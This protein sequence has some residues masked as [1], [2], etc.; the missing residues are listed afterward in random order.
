[1]KRKFIF[2]GM[3]FCAFSFFSV[4]QSK[5]D[6]QL[7]HWIDVYEGNENPQY[8]VCAGGGEDCLGGDVKKYPKGAILV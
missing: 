2:L 6:T 1:M 8:A 3:F 4:N 5:A 7:G